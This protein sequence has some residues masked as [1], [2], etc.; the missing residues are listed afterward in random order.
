MPTHVP[1]WTLRLSSRRPMRTRSIVRLLTHERHILVPSATAFEPPT[2]VYETPEG[3]VV[4]LEVAGLKPNAPDVTV[5]IDGDH[6]T[7]AGTRPDPAAGTTDPRYEQIEI[8]TGRFE[9]TVHLPCP[10]TETEA[11]ARYDDGF[12]VITLPKKEP[13]RSSVR[14]VRID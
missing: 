5:E 8:Q 3:V 10:V 9:R 6:L 14:M 4:R 11:H 13:A 2:D 12:L 1:D 7:V